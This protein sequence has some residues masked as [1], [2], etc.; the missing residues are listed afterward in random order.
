MENFIF[1]ELTLDIILEV[2]YT[3]IIGKILAYRFRIG[4]VDEFSIIIDDV[5]EGL[6]PFSGL[7][8]SEG[9]EHLYIHVHNDNPFKFI[10]V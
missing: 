6:R 8:L 10:V 1:I 7:V 5:I 9:I 3:D 4:T 2:I